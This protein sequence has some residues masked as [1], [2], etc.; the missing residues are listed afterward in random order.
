VT[1]RHRL[2]AL[3][4]FAFAPLAAHAQ[5]SVSR[6]PAGCTYETCALRVEPAFFSAPRLLRGHQGV[7]VG[8]LGAFGGGVDT[9]LAGPDSAAMQAR[10]YV[11]SIRTANTLALLS[12]AAFVVVATRTDW[13]R[14]DADDTD[15]VVGITG[16][17]LA[18]VSIPFRVSAE[19]SLARAVWLYNAALAR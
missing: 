8:R 2:A 11:T 12:A 9:L 7:V 15:R 10:R 17:A 6:A 19:R 18:L 16:T 14:D 1:R 13:F 4:T 5:S 3:V